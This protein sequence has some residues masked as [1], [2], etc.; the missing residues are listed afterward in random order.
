VTSRDVSTACEVL[1]VCILLHTCNF[2]LTTSDNVTKCLLLSEC[3]YLTGS[4]SPPRAI[5]SDGA[6]ASTAGGPERSDPVSNIKLR[7]D[8]VVHCDSDL[9]VRYYEPSSSHVTLYLNS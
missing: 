5:A 2:T 1:L 8:L 9:K 4:R 3:H 7:A 6:S